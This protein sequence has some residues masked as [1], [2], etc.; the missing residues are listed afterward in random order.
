MGGTN[1]RTAENIKILANKTIAVV[2][3]YGK[4]NFGDELMASRLSQVL[5][6]NGNTVS[7]YSD[8][9]ADGVLD[10]TKDASYLDQD[11]IV[12]GGGGIVTTD[13]WA[14][15]QPMLEELRKSR[16]LIAFLNVNV[17]PECCEDAEFTSNLRS[18]NA[19]WWVRDQMSVEILAGVGIKAELVPDISFRVDLD[20]RDEA[21]P[22]SPY[23]QLSVFAN[24]YTLEGLWE[25]D[26][27][28]FIAAKKSANILAKYLDWMITFGWR[29]TF[30][31]AQTA[32]FVDDRLAAAAVY[33]M[34]KNKEEATWVTECPDWKMLVQAV[35]ASDLVVS[36]RYHTTTTALANGIPFV[37]ITH[38]A[39]NRRLLAETS[40]SDMAVEFDQLSHHSLVRATQRAEVMS[41][42]MKAIDAYRAEA[43]TRW[44]KF[45]LAWDTFT[46]NST[47]Y[48]AL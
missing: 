11:V 37:D 21:E 41:D 30:W 18:L 35:Y 44:N 46:E 17:T 1:I 40:T 19:R 32:P 14:L 47:R 9:C 15:R 29:V 7:I 3:W 26:L 28:R 8:L 34:M 42:D 13:F 2:G 43:Q 20:R 22:R 27:D 23:R 5:S 24:Y 31:P 10:G 12:I 16:A 25:N 6:R 38:H 39:K 48:E 45:D 36:M 33:A 4:K